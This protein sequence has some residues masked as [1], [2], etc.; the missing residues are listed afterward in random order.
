MDLG[1][2]PL[3]PRQ[4]PRMK[5]SA[6]SAKIRKATPRDAPVIASVLRQAFVEYERLYTAKG[7][8]AT[9]PKTRDIHLLMKAG[10]VWVAIH[11][12]QIV[13]TVSAVPKPA[14]IYVRGMAVLPAARGLG[15]G[16]LLLQ[17]IER[18]AVANGC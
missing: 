17:E 1:T 16:Y 8:A 7:Y 2:V 5:E 6:S 4:Y 18:F 10:P 9:T 15:I 14:G 12:G 3:E 13:G 11:E